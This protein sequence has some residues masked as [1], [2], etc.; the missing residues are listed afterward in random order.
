MSN[1]LIAVMHIASCW[2]CFFFCKSEGGV[3]HNITADYDVKYLD[4]V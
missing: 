2:F 1:N 4:Y 3:M